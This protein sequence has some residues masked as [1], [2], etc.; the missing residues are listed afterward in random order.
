MNFT[1]PD[2][3]YSE[4]ELIELYN[5]TYPKLK[6]KQQQFP[7]TPRAQS[8]NISPFTGG[9]PDGYYIA[10][11]GDKLA[12]WAG[13]KKIDGNT[14]MTS[15]SFTFKDYKGMGIQKEL[16]KKRNAMFGGAP[17]LT[18]ARSL[19]GEGWYSFI[20]TYYPRVTVDEL[21]EKLRVGVQSSID[22]YL[23]KGKLEP[24]IFYRG[25]TE[26]S[27]TED[28]AMQKAWSIIKANIDFK[29]VLPEYIQGLRHG[30]DTAG[31]YNITRN[32]IEIFPRTAYNFLK[33]KL[34]R[35]PK[36]EELIKFITAIVNHEAGHAAD[37]SVN[38]YGLQR[39]IDEGHVI[40]L[41]RT[42]EIDAS[43]EWVAFQ[44]QHPKDPYLAMKGFLRHPYTYYHD[45]A[46]STIAS[47]FSPR[48]K[49]H[50]PGLPQ[51][52]R[53]IVEY[54]D[55]HA[56]TPKQKNELSRLE[57]SMRG[58]EGEH[59]RLPTNALGAEKRYGKEHSKFLSTLRW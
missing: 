25:P 28:S 49:I 1:F 19:Q 26:D 35:E 33:G 27:P 41:P 15:G 23:E 47:I 46:D 29:V 44:S 24:V 55:K 13:W 48:E 39:F 14:Y 3:I 20:E 58:R 45:T 42:Y 2:K 16:W 12:G 57:L 34:G 32:E 30:R 37:Y 7:R 56:K 6:N 22:F 54:V 17:V 9:T 31:V 21:P 59:K 43:R 36:D 8:K 52:I 50:Y 53:R 10:L 40:R 11:D 18:V 51:S 38:P 5:A 4:A